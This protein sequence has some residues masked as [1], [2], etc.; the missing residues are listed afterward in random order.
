MAEAEIGKR[1]SEGMANMKN[2]APFLDA[3]LGMSWYRLDCL[4]TWWMISS[5][6]RLASELLWALCDG[7]SMHQSVLRTRFG[8]AIH[9]LGMKG[10]VML[11][12]DMEMML[13]FPILNCSF[14]HYIQ[15]LF[16]WV[17]EIVI[18]LHKGWSS[19][20]QTPPLPYTSPPS[21]TPSLAFDCLPGSQHRIICQ[22]DWG[23]FFLLT[24]HKVCIN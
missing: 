11:P 24:W 23:L 1:R 2:M 12:M 9:F 7:N 13:Y 4:L 21:H 6:K 18:S 19:S 5:M 15:I 3:P 14:N 22:F 20:S 16:S 17:R 8:N 10:C